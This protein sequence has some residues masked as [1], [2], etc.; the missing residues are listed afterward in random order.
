MEGNSGATRWR[1]ILGEDQEGEEWEEWEECRWEGTEVV[2]ITGAISGRRISSTTRTSAGEMEATTRCLSGKTS[3]TVT[4]P[5]SSF[6]E[7]AESAAERELSTV[8]G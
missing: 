1:E 8:T 2:E 3:T 7:I 6:L 4:F 5:P